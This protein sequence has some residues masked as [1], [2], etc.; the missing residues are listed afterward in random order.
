MCIHA[1]YILRTIYTL[2]S[3]EGKISAVLTKHGKILEIK[4]PLGQK[5]EY[6]TLI[7]WVS[8]HSL[9][10]FDIVSDTSKSR[11]LLPGLDTKGFIIPEESSCGWS[12]WCY[13]IVY[14]VCPYLLDDEAFRTI[15]NALT[16]FII[17]NNLKLIDGNFISFY[18]NYRYDIATHFP[19]TISYSY[20]LDTNTFVTNPFDTT[21]LQALYNDLRNFVLPHLNCD[22]TLNNYN[23]LVLKNNVNMVKCHTKRLNSFQ[24]KLARKVAHYNSMIRKYTRKY[25][26][27]I[28]QITNKYA[29]LIQNC[30]VE[31]D[32]I[33][34][35]KTMPIDSSVS[36]LYY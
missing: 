9:T 10:L 27:K 7:D 36:R 21:V 22:Y 4:N 11:G 26:D 15:Y 35:K 31:I 2:F 1:P 28:R 5:R 25:D 6:D 33:Q 13:E 18:N 8:A 34:G 14:E 20:T 17:S 3:N 12:R 23:T 19:T 32:R 29:P 24:N 30:Q 16:S